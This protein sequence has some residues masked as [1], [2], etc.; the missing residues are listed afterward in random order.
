MRDGVELLGLLVIELKD[1]VLVKPSGKG[2]DV[3]W[4]YV[5]KWDKARTHVTHEKYPRHDGRR[6]RQVRRIPPRKMVRA[7]VMMFSQP[8]DPVPKFGSLQKR[9]EQ[10]KLDAWLRRT[11]PKVFHPPTDEP[12]K[13]L[14]DGPVK[15][16]LNACMTPKDGVE[17]EIGP[18]LKKGWPTKKVTKEDVIKVIREN[19]MDADGSVIG[20]KDNPPRTVFAFKD[21]MVMELHNSSIEKS[22]IF[23]EGLLGIEGFVGTLERK[24][25]LP[26]G[27]DDKK[28]WLS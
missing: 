27:S 7:E 25:L 6:H 4:S 15:D 18:L 22:Q 8:G 19:E 9:S 11:L 3:H 24:G 26:K 20:F 17:V 1:E 12:V 2:V 13:V 28:S 14:R 21:G 23:K 10:K 5:H 16:F